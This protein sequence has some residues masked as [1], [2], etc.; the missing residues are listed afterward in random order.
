MPTSNRL[1]LSIFVALL[2]FPLHAFSET[3][4]TLDAYLA[5]LSSGRKIVESPT[6]IISAQL[7]QRIFGVVRWTIKTTD[8]YALPSDEGV[9]FVLDDVSGIGLTEVA[10]SKLLNLTN[11]HGMVIEVAASSTDTF[12]VRQVFFSP[13]GTD[14]YRFAFRNN[15][16]YLAG[17]DGERIYDLS[18]S[19]DAVFAQS[20]NFLTGHTITKRFNGNRLVSQRRK[21]KRYP[22]FPLEDFQFDDPRHRPWSSEQPGTS[23]TK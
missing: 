16:W 23:V 14:S 8:P 7:R 19:E 11:H 18:A 17:V 15:G 10:R 20:T 2:V 9:I 3:F 4:G 6:A 21:K 13:I 22:R 1:A 12:I 5:H